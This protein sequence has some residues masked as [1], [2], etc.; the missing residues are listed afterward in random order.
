M[1]DELPWAAEAGQR[2]QGELSMVE[3]LGR[4]FA[5]T[6][7]A[8]RG[9][10]TLREAAQLINEQEQRRQA[11]DGTVAVTISFSYLGALRTG[12]RDNPSFRQIAALAELFGVSI[13]YFTGTGPEVEQ[14]DADL[15]LVA[16]LRDRRLRDL[17]LRAAQLTPNSRRTLLGVLHG[18]ESVPGM[19]RATANPP[20]SSISDVDA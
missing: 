8:D 12:A 13:S 19:T 14:I 9:P 1:S 16:A 11:A 3:K 20:D 7:P 15:A 10:Y 2:R 6:H 5:T 4:L 18:L 17:V